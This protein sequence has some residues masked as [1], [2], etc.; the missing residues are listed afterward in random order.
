M[1]NYG[2]KDEDAWYDYQTTTDNKFRW[3]NLNAT[4]AGDFQLS[5]RLSN[6]TSFIA[7]YSYTNQSMSE[8]D[9]YFPE[10]EIRF[11]NSLDISHNK[12]SVVS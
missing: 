3:G 11:R 8:D 9:I 1:D 10:P 2:I 6:S 4:L 12:T 5:N 7:S